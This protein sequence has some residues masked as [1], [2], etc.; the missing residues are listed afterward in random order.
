MT[1]FNYFKMERVNW[2]IEII[3]IYGYVNRRHVMRKFGISQPQASQD[4]G[5]AAVIDKRIVYNT[6]EKRYE[7]YKEFGK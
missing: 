5:D 4:L 1:H 3:G 6:S 7:R 2:I